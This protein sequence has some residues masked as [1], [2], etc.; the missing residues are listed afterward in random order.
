MT[1][2][3][4]LMDWVEDSVDKG[5][6]TVEE[7]HRAIA[8]LPLTVME[9]NGVL[10]ETAADVRKIQ[11]SSIGAVYD[12]VRDINHKVVRLASDLLETRREEQA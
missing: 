6:T 7:I 1:E 2:E 9:R 11:D 4:P 10:A 12:L 8:D 5:T 3:R